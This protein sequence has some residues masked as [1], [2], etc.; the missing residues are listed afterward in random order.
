MEKVGDIETYV[1]DKF[2]LVVGD[3]EL[4]KRLRVDHMSWEEAL[5]FLR[6]LRSTAAAAPYASAVAYSGS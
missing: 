1:R 5:E 4:A 3:A 2:A 6:W